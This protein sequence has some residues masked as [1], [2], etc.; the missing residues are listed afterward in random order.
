M[1]QIISLCLL[2]IFYVPSA[3]AGDVQVYVAP[4]L[5]TD[6]FK[7]SLEVAKIVQKTHGLKVKLLSSSCTDTPCQIM[8]AKRTSAEIL[9]TLE[10][11][12]VMGFLVADIRVYDITENSVEV[13]ST[14]AEGATKQALM[15]SIQERVEPLAKDKLRSLKPSV[16]KKEP[17]L[18]WR[19]SP[20]QRP[21]RT[22]PTR[23]KRQKIIVNNFDTKNIS[24]GV[25]VGAMFGDV[26]RR[27]DTRIGVTTSLQTYSIYEYDSWITGGPSTGLSISVGFQV[28]PKIEASLLFGGASYQKELTTGWEVQDP[29]YPGMVIEEDS[30][31]Y[32]PTPSSMLT[33]EPRINIQIIKYS[34]LEPYLISGFSFRVFD[35][36]NPPNLESVQ[37]SPRPG[38]SHY[39]FTMGAGL[40][41]F[42][43]NHRAV[44]VEIPYT[45]WLN[46][47]VYERY[48]ISSN[49]AASSIETIPLQPSNTNQM[50]AFNIGLRAEF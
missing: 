27:Y 26:V 9:F 16:S 32:D 11:T 38:G 49:T 46:S 35:G 14:E 2:F 43:S 47:N 42:G 15:K 22:E 40:R 10:V 4:T 5:G 36:Y 28:T 20:Q 8:E 37:Y 29:S 19:Q 13:A 21:Q 44:Y 24:L 45:F 3:F 25:Q 6:S 31:T 30:V 48:D 7:T 41:V 50:I 12:N 17:R 18:T 1:K 39:G 33:I 34:G 23:K